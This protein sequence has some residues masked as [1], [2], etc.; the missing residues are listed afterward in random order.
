MKDFSRESRWKTKEQ[1]IQGT[2]K[3]TDSQIRNIT[4]DK[5]I[6]SRRRTRNSD[7]NK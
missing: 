1:K 7:K 3:I 4:G 6:T 2:P 5:K